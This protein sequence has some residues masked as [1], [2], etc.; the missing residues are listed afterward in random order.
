MDQTA[1][2]NEYDVMNCFTKFEKF[3]PHSISMQS[4]MAVGGQMPKL[5]PE[6]G[7][8]GRNTYQ[9]VKIHIYLS[10]FNPIHIGVKDGPPRNGCCTALK[11]ELLWIIYK[12][13]HHTV[14]EYVNIYSQKSFQGSTQHPTH[15][16]SRRMS[17]MNVRT[18]LRGLRQFMIG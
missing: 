15:F 8:G 16:S 7:G 3:L 10:I 6:G 18:A 5:D 4:F 17:Q 1:L 2:N 14:K 9:V 13:M 12:L 11:A